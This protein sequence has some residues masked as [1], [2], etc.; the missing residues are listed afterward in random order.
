LKKITNNA[1]SILNLFFFKRNSPESFALIAFLCLPLFLSCAETF[2]F[3]FGVLRR[4]KSQ[5]NIGMPRKQ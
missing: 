1:H 3:M 2:A 5:K 4:R